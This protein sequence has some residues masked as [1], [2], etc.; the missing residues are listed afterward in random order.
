MN[1]KQYHI[2]NG[3]ALRMQ[4]PKDIDGEII[5]ARECLVDG[6]VSGNDLNA[7]FK[8]RSEFI[9]RNYEGTSV[10]M[11]YK[12][13]VPEFLKVQSIP[14]NVDVNLWF[15]D[16]LFCQVN[17]WF[18]MHLLCHAANQNSIYLVR[19]KV[20]NTYGFGGLS[21]EDLKTLYLNKIEIHHPETISQ[22]WEAYQKNDLEYLTKSAGEL[23][24]YPFI[25]NA[26]E[27]HIARNPMGNDGGKPMKT[28]KEI[29]KNLGPDNFGKVFAEFNKKESIYGFGDLQV[30]K[31]LDEI[32]SN[33]K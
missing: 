7:I 16:D 26:V 8:T 21:I 25:M 33:P 22:L 11:Y 20:H 5:V 6:D 27:A 15:E 14:K 31:M 19:P 13:V 9:S 28:L 30:K 29:V 1:K 2:L 32:I 17:F 4:F 23:P 12:S 3:D 18:I 10:D 24:E